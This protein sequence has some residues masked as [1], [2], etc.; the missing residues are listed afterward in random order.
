MR[1]LANL[2][3]VVVTLF[4]S[5]PAHGEILIYK[6]TATGY[7]YNRWPDH[8]E[9]ET[10]K[11]TGFLVLDVIYNE[12]GTIA[13]VDSAKAIAYWKDGKD[14]WFHQEDTDTQIDRIGY[15]GKVQWVLWEQHTGE[16]GADVLLVTGKA[17]EKDV[18]KEDKREVG[19]KLKGSFLECEHEEEP[20]EP[21]AEF[22]IVQ[23][24][25]SLQSKW[26]RHANDDEK[27][28]GQDYDAT[29]EFVK[30]YLEGKGYEEEV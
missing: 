26:T 24:T 8:G 3:I 4:L 10:E 20:G 25:F 17:Y 19:T 18:G 12:D 21:E 1:V 28:L 7:A 27:G 6:Y 30:E 23:L 5:L 15:D 14:K 2:S 11:E 9:V 16:Y 22:S 13:S 29:V